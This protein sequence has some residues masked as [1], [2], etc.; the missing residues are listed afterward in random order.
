MQIDFIVVN[1]I[2]F[3]SNHIKISHTKW[4]VNSSFYVC[5]MSTLDLNQNVLCFK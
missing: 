2:V 4:L 1:R 3:E 5:F